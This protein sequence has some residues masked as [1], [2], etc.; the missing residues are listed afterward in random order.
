MNALPVTPTI[1]IA[2]L[3]IRQDADGRYSLADLHQAS[4]GEKRH[5]PNYWLDI[6]QT[7][8]LI[9]ELAKSLNEGD[10]GIP[11]SPEIKHLTPVVTIRGGT[12][13]QGTFVVRELVYSYAM[14]ISPSFHLMVIRTFDAVMTGTSEP[15]TLTPAEQQTLVE[16]AHARCAG[17]DPEIQGKALS[18]IW[19]RVHRKFRVAK[20]SQLPR[21]QFADAVLYLIAMD[22]RSLPKPP[23]LP[24]ADLEA[25]PAPALP[26]PAYDPI[27]DPK[28]QAAINAKAHAISLD[29]F[30]HN[31]QILEDHL[32][33]CKDL[34]DPEDAIARIHPLEL[35]HGMRE[36]VDIQLFHGLAHAVRAAHL[37]SER[38]MQALERI[39]TSTGHRWG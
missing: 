23:V 16:I 21:A 39:E 1:R 25:A 38:Q 5:S 10:T 17:C 31:R 22:V 26:A 20:Y 37:A 19:S 18:E 28:V 34:T 3:A 2:D 9:D 7:K 15:L 11:V 6:Q 36:M 4:G 33:D 12:G 8:D 27:A 14:W 29:A 35:D 13:K 32:R 30:A 24:S